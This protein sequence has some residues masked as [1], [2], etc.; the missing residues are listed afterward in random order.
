MRSTVVRRTLVGLGAVIGIAAGSLVG[1]G[2]AQAAAPTG[3]TTATVGVLTVNNLGLTTTLAT[4]IQRWVCRP[5][6]YE[7][8]LDGLLGTESWKALQRWLKNDGYYGGAI[9]GT[10]NTATV[11]GLQRYLKEFHQYTGKIDGIA[12]EGTRAAFKRM[13]QS[14]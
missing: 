6:G 13:A 3:V 1:V 2:T 7:G 11:K 9:N 5:W 4:D 14:M 12:G 8:R 10:V